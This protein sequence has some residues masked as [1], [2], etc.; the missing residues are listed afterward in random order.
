MITLT[1]CEQTTIKTVSECLKNAN[2]LLHLKWGTKAIILTKRCLW[3]C[4]HN[5]GFNGVD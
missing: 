3:F 2:C 4:S 5:N 1:V